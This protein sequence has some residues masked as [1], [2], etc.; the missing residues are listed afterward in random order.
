MAELFERTEVNFGG[1]MHGQFGIMSKVAGI[2]IGLLLQNVNMNYGQQVS[3]I[4]E[5][6]T[7]GSKT[8]VFFIAGRAQGNLNAAHVI[9]PGVALKAYYDKFS[10]VCEIGTNTLDIHLGPNIC[11]AAAG[12]AAA[13]GGVGGFFNGANIF[14]TAT[15]VA[16]A[17]NNFVNGGPVGAVNNNPNSRQLSYKM[18]FCLLTSI[19]MSAGAQDFVINEN[20]ALMFNGLEY[21]GR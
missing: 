1:A 12:G 14:T 6:G 19:G 16:N 10:D 20:S 15:N 2:E 3:R 18:K 9:G 7:E 17:V 8:R 13:G 4:Y 11:G 5:L 21:N